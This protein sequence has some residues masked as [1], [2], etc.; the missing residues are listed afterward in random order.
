[1]DIKAKSNDGTAMDA[2]PSMSAQEIST[3]LRILAHSGILAQQG[4]LVL[5]SQVSIDS[6]FTESGLD[7]I[8]LA[9]TQKLFKLSAKL[10][11]DE[12]Q[13]GWINLIPPALTSCSIIGSV[14]DQLRPP[15]D[16]T[17][18][19][20]TLIDCFDVIL[21]EISA[22]ADKALVNKESYKSYVK[23]IDESYLAFAKEVDVRINDLSGSS[24]VIKATKKEIEDLK[25]DLMLQ[26]DNIMKNAQDIGELIQKMV[27]GIITTFMP[28]KLESATDSSQQQK[29]E[30]LPIT[31]TDF[32][33]GI[34]GMGDACQQYQDDI[35]HLGVLYQKLHSEEE[36]LA[37][38]I[39]IEGQTRTYV[40]DSKAMM[41]LSASFAQGWKDTESNFNSVYKQLLATDISESKLVEI[42]DNFLH[43]ANG[44]WKAFKTNLLKLS[45]ALSGLG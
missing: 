22:N 43:E 7:A 6:F 45:R 37:I 34:T 11:L 32:K 36:M 1:M 3:R 28:G 13:A 5:L 30:G 29:N 42:K 2:L 14:A 23:K 27:P 24:G 33:S 38:A 26:L 39:A 20:Q 17:E 31:G 25:K 9:A 40:D 8:P 44:G 4:A 10:Y 16:V 35:A 18:L 41:D 15:I 12:F 19:R 21:V